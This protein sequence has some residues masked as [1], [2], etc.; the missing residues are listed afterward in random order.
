MKSQIWV[1]SS[2][3]ILDKLLTNAKF[4]FQNPAIWLLL[5]FSLIYKLISITIISVFKLK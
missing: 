5:K 2:I 3:R 4:H 1:F